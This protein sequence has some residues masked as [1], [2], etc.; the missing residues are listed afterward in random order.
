MVMPVPCNRAVPHR[1]SLLRRALFASCLVLATGCEQGRTLGRVAGNVTLDGEAC[2]DVMVVFAC[3]E[4]RAF[5]TAV[6]D[7]DGA[8]EVQMAEGRGL[9]VGTYQVSIRPAPPQ[10]WD[11][12]QAPVPIPAKPYSVV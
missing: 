5:I 1:G 8:Y 3:R 12:P 6:V 10:N 9:P 11:R 7:A 2:R 4:E